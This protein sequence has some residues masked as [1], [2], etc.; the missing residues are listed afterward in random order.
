M[1]LHGFVDKNVYTKNVN[2]DFW[3]VVLVVIK[4][5]NPL[6]FFLSFVWM[7]CTFR[8]VPMPVRSTPYEQ[9]SGESDSVL[10]SLKLSIFK[11]GTMWP[12]ILFTKMATFLAV[13][14]KQ[15][16][17]VE[18]IKPLRS[19]IQNTFSQVEPDDYN[20]ALNEFSKLRNLMIAKSVD[21]HESALEVLYRFVLHIFTMF[22]VSLFIEWGLMCLWFV[23]LIV[24]Y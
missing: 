16:Q 2:Q 14:L 5:V 7:V 22:T 4:N 17:E 3:I 19:F 18:L 8:K 11:C 20:H 1:T 9:K 6:K 24:I 23:Y 12:N 13:P 21:K 15:T 10:T